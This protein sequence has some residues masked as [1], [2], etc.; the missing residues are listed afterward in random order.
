MEIWQS[1]D[2]E[3]WYVN[4]NGVNYEFYTQAEA[5]EMANKLGLAKAIISQA[6]SIAPVMDIAPDVVQEYFDSAVTFSDA[7]VEALGITAAELVSVIT[8]LENYNKF[9]AGTTPIDAQ[10]RVTIN[11]V[12]RVNING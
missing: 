1:G 4:I 2:S 12:R 8:M 5:L 3:K 6:Q 7:D 10:Y 11:K 9:F